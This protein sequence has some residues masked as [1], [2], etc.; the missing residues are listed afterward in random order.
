MGATRPSQPD[1]SARYTLSV[2]NNDTSAC[3]NST[4]GLAIDSETG[5]TGSFLLPST[6]SAGSVTLA[7]GATN[8]TVTLTVTGNGTGADG[9]ALTTTVSAS[10][11]TNHAGQSQ[12]DSVT[13]TIVVGATGPTARGD[14]YATPVYNANKAEPGLVVEASRVS[15]VLYN[16]FGG[17]PP[18]TAQLVSGPSN[19]YDCS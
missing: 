10:D 14:T 19:A 5:N 18:L 9:D 11:A 8:T 2:T 6:L 13:T 3:P 15:G 17:T 7:P 16:D 12:T 1:G 4:F